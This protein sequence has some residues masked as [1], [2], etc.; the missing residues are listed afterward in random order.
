MNIQN[1]MTVPEAASRWGINPRT[2]RDRLN[3]DRRPALQKELDSG[4]VKYYKPDGAKQGEW[5]L[6]KDALELWYGIEP[7][8]S[9]D[10]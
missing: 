8:K 3:I 1:Y 4:L 10:E 2:L 5:I 7:K 6:S 9:G